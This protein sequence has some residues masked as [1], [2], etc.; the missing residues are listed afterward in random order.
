L[1]WSK[2]LGVV[3]EAVEKLKHKNIENIT[4]YVAGILDDC[5]PDRIELEQILD[6]EKEGKLYG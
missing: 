6:W 5:D 2:G 4:L 3:V 1:L